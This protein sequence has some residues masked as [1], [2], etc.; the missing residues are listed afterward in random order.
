MTIPRV[1][2]ITD[3]E[4]LDTQTTSLSSKNS[5]EQAALEAVMESVDPATWP[6]LTVQQRCALG[7]FGKPRTSYSRVEDSPGIEALEPWWP[8]LSALDK[9]LWL[10][11]AKTFKIVPNVVPQGSIW[12]LRA[13][14]EQPDKY[15]YPEETVIQLSYG[16]SWMDALR[17][18]LQPLVA[19]TRYLAFQQDSLRV[20]ESCLSVVLYFKEA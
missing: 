14:I 18:A 10:G 20:K 13:D 7:R 5:D 3:L 15:L 19:R 9:E 4:N 17:Q 6:G 11:L 8:H 2:Q 12:R 16:S 1:K